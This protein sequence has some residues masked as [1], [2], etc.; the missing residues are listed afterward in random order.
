MRYLP[1]ILIVI[2]HCPAFCQDE[3]QPV[4]STTRPVIRS[5][6]Q[7]VSEEIPLVIAHRGASG[8]VPEHTLEAAAFAHALGADYIEQDVV[9]SKDGVPVVA[10]DVTLDRISNVSEEFPGRDVEGK[11]YVWDFSLA[12][13]RKLRITERRSADFGQRFPKESGAFR[14]S[15]LAEHI[16]LIQGMNHSRQR[17]AGI[18][19]EIK[20]PAGHRE[21]GL[22]ASTAVLKV[23]SDF[24]YTDAEDRVYVQCFDEEEILRLRTELNCRLP[25][26]QLMSRKPTAEEVER[27]SKVADGLGLSIKAILKHSGGDAKPAITDVVKLAHRHSLIVHAWTF[28]TDALPEYCESPKALI[29]LLVRDAGVDGLFADQPDVVTAWRDA[30]MKEQPQRGPFHLLRDR[31]KE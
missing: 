9:L 23:L 18:Y 12:E 2:T 4:T 6:S 24:G 15:T 5:V 31:T 30:L 19:V 8:Y 25:L 21:H 26:I 28:R 7:T 14:L 22:D 20:N 27:I 16:T 10:H 29:D 1:A 13:L 17:E 3:N 11:F